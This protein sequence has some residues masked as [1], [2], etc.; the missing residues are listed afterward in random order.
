MH[1]ISE[2]I[3]IKIR[4]LWRDRTDEGTWPDRRHPIDAGL[5][6]LLDQKTKE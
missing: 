6:S 5:M 3:D 4:C 2:E 1:Y